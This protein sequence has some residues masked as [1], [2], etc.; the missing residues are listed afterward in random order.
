[1][2]TH[3]GAESGG[4]GLAL[5]SLRWQDRVDIQQRLVVAGADL[6]PT[7]LCMV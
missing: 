4:W 6:E 5:C 3:Q 7:S 2:A 1:M